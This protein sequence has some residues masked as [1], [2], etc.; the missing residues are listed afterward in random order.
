MSARAPV[1]ADPDLFI[2]DGSGR[3]WPAVLTI[4]VLAAAVLL[5]FSRAG[6]V[7]QEFADPDDAMRLLQVRDW[8]AGQSW[9]DVSQHRLGGGA[10]AMHWSR[11]VDLP[12]AAGFMLLTPVVGAPWAERATMAVVPLLA[13]LVIMGVAATVTR[14]M[15]GAAAARA[16][17]PLAPLTVPILMQASPMRIDH[18]HWQIALALGGVTALLS[19]PGRRAGVLAG[20][21]LAALITVSMEGLPI[22]VAVAG[23]AALAWAWNPERWR[24]TLLWLI[25][26]LFGAAL[27]FHVATRGPGLLAHACDAVSPVWLAALAAAAG[28][29][30]AAASLPRAR[31]TVRLAAL[32]ATGAA[33]GGILLLAAPDCLSGPFAM[34]D[35]L[36]RSVWYDNVAEG[37]PLW[38]QK[39]IWAV[40][41]AALPAVALAGC[42][43]GWRRGDGEARERWAML[44]AITLAA[45]VIMATV[46][47]AGGVANAIALPGA[48][49]VLAGALRPIRRISRTAPRAF[50]TAGAIL[51]ASPGLAIGVSARIAANVAHSPAKTKPDGRARLAC[52]GYGDVRVLRRLPTSAIF[53]PLDISPGLLATTPHRAV[54]S[55]YHRNTAAIHRVIETFLGS[56][57]RAERLVRETGS[58]FVAVCAGASELSV[59]RRRAPNGFYAR[60]ERGERF[61]WLRPVPLPGSPPVRAWEVLPR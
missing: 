54:A 8:L 28:G 16:A 43:L 27:A 21:S 53:L 47:R 6:V 42:A 1:P 59:Y 7:Q 46:T 11:L 36:V 52:S 51:L 56:P 44:F 34:L 61:A 10:F 19:G 33:A 20:L 60:L 23:T 24:E 38:R 50:A 9:W 29:T 18:H 12:L 35:P 45:A 48:A 57:E 5:W 41:N 13:L 4:W 17:V 49:L 25:W 40:V 37:L 22:T 15:L 31:S 58:R 39:P 2:G 14:R 26:T 32:G 30:T 3:V 55:G